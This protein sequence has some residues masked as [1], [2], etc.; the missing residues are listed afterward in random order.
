MSWVY[1]GFLANEQ[2]KD[3]PQN[4]QRDHD[5]PDNGQTMIVHFLIKVPYVGFPQNTGTLAGLWARH[6]P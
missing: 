6:R 3:G 5:G 4:I 2:T 1:P